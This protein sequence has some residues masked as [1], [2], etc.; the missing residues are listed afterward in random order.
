[1]SG[2]LHDVH[3]VNIA[4]TVNVIAWVVASVPAFTAPMA[5][6]LLDVCHG[7]LCITVE[8]T[9]EDAKAKTQ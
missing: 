2:H 9:E 3:N 7:Y 1:M 6:R 5:G 8:V 4:V